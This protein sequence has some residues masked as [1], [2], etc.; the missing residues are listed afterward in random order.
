MV[1]SAV[2]EEFAVCGFGGVVWAA[3]WTEVVVMCFIVENVT[4]KA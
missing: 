1:E 3:G 4:L 2:A